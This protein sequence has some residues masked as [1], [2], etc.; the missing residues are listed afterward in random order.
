M[1][2][3]KKIHLE[4]LWAWCWEMPWGSRGSFCPQGT[5][6]PCWAPLFFGFFFGCQVYGILVP[7]PILTTGQ[8][9]QS[10]AHRLCSQLSSDHAPPSEPSVSTLGYKWFFYFSTSKNQ[11]P[12]F[13]PKSR[14]SVLHIS[15]QHPTLFA[16]VTQLLSDSH[17]GER[18]HFWALFP[19]P[20]LLLWFWIW[21]RVVSGQAQRPRRL[22]DL[23]TEPRSS[24]LI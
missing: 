17:L 5:C 15:D 12:Y 23:A 4:L 18:P 19:I 13:F 24:P 20:S 3:I 1:K 7:G 8:P 9:G 14:S 21:R 2:F 11:M 16:Q 6:Q 22:T 10:W